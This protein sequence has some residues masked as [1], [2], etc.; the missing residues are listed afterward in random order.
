VEVIR[1]RGEEVGKRFRGGNG[2]GDVVGFEAGEEPADANASS[3][4]GWIITIS[5]YYL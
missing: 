1:K 4:G 5:T 3:V 2:K